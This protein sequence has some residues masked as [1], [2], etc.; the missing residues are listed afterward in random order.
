MVR[1]QITDLN[2]ILRKMMP[3]LHLLDDQCYVITLGNK[4]EL[5]MP[6]HLQL[7]VNP[8]VQ[9]DFFLPRAL[10]ILFEESSI[11]NRAE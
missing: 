8:S 7:R 11:S 6:E 3:D 5:Q 4:K 2:T 1:L 10:T 9:D